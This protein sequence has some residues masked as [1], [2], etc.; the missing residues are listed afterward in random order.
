LPYQLTEYHNEKH[1]DDEIQDYLAKPECMR[2]A[3]CIAL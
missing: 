1:L 3:Q 2:L